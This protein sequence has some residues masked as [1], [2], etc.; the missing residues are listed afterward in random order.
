MFLQDPAVPSTLVGA[1]QV[2]LA[3]PIAWLASKLY[4]GLKQ[5]LDWYDNL[6]AAVHGFLQPLLAFGLGWIT[7]KGGVEAVTDIH[8]VTAGVI[9]GLITAGVSAGIFRGQKR[10]AA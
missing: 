9:G 5:K 1:L 4:D 6:P 3:A 8:G 7:T 2:A 10:A